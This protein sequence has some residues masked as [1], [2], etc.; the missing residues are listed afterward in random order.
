MAPDLPLL[1]VAATLNFPPLLGSRAQALAWIVQPVKTLSELFSSVSTAVLRRSVGCA[2][3]LLLFI[4]LEIST[5]NI[6]RAMYTH[7][8]TCEELLN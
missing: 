3:C 6:P 1:L 4:S 8:H 7:E 5:R 2:K